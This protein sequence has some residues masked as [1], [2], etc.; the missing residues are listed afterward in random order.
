MNKIKDKI[1]IFVYNKEKNKFLLSSLAKNLPPSRKEI[2]FTLTK[3]IKD[4]KKRKN[5]IKK[6]VKSQTGLI[7][8]DILSLNWGR[9][10]KLKNWEFKEMSFI[11]FVKS[12]EL[13]LKEK[14]IKHK[15]VPLKTFI[16]ELDWSDNRS[17][18]KNVLERGI[19]KEVYFDKKEREE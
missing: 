18:L 1:L 6:E 17:L 2:W 11:A 7:V 8:K 5:I 19:N 15:W 13:I 16:K 12:S 3:E 14:N 4:I 10:Y 9:T